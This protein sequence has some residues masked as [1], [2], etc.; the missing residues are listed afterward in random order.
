MT[1]THQQI[2]SLLVACRETREAEIDCEQFL[3][4]LA[5]YAEARAEGRA[6]PETLTR[7]AEHE[8]LCA[9]C[10]EECRALVEMIEE[11]ATK[12]IGLQKVALEIDGSQRNFRITFRR[13]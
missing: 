6:I 13:F 12:T 11:S 8:R 5:P 7:A 10:A 1:L 3:A 4:L 2:H 9:N